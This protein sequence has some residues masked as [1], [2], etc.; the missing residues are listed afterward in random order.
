[1]PIHFNSNRSTKYKIRIET[2]YD[3]DTQPDY[4]VYWAVV[5]IATN[6]SLKSL[7]QVKMI[8][9]NV[10]FGTTFG[11]SEKSSNSGMSF[12]SALSGEWV[13]IG[14][15]VNGSWLFKIEGD[16]LELKKKEDGSWNTKTTTTP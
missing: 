7:A 15:D 9:S 4:E 11:G 10:D 16:N 14:A 12:G 1:V 2:V 3:E 13:R 6:P 8:N 5:N